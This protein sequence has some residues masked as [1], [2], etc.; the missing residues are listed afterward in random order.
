MSWNV[1]PQDEAL[2]LLVNRLDSTESIIPYDYYQYVLW[3]S[4][5]AGHVSS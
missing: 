4:L 5:P 3:Q 1:S 2:P